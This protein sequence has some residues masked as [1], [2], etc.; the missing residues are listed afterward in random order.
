MKRLLALGFILLI[1]FSCRK[2]ESKKIDI[3]TKQI[4]GIGETIPLHVTHVSP[5]GSVEGERQT[6]KILMSEVETISEVIFKLNDKILGQR[7][8]PFECL[9]QPIPGEHKLEVIGEGKTLSQIDRVSFR[10]F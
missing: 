9:W 5:T 2:P 3:T 1:I 8:Y 10:V 7:K 4:I 6:F